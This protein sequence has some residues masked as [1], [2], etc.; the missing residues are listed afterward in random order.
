MSNRKEVEEKHVQQVIGI[1]GDGKLKDGGAASNEFRE[2]LGM[3]PS[4]LLGRYA[5]DCLKEKFENSGLALQDIIN[6]VGAR[7]GFKV[8]PGRY[9]GTPGEV[10]FDGLWYAPDENCIVVEVK[11]TDAYR[12]ALDTVAVY[13]QKL[14]AENRLAEGKSSIL[15]VVGRSDTG[16][17]EAQVRGSRHAW[18]I[19]MISID[20]LL[21]LMRSK[22][23]LGDPKIIS[24][25]RQV[26][27]KHEITSVKRIIDHAF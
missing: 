15:I 25:S 1:A 8:E 19:R 9:R 13:R 18:D 16:D 21:R 5:D 6:Q 11:T 10:G 7:L 14:I 4:T 24:K 17:L 2:F 20:F 27:M 12:I 22:E 23:A 26:L 3:V